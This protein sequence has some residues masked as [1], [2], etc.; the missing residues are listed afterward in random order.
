MSLP[1]PSVR[2]IDAY[3]DKIN[4]RFGTKFQIPIMFFTQLLALALGADRY[5]IRFKENIV[6]I[7][8]KI[9]GGAS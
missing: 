2:L 5:E 4:K 8:E 3:Q 1:A 6:P 9:L 7:P